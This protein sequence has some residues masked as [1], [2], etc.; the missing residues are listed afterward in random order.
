MSLQ[1]AREGPSGEQSEDSDD[2]TWD[3]PLG[4]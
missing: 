4:V 3:R 1:E 2:T